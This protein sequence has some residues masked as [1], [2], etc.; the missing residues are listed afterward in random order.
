MT[1]RDLL[2]VSLGS[3]ASLLFLRSGATTANRKRPNIIL[4]LTDDQDKESIN[5]FNG[6]TW[7]PNFDR[8]AKE[9][10]KFNS[11]PYNLGG[12]LCVYMRDPDG[13]T[14]ELMQF[15]VEP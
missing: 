11:K 8:M 9:G 14:V 2:K 12:G 4:F 6:K 5:A 3:T 13:I 7:S 1:R 10:I 15:D